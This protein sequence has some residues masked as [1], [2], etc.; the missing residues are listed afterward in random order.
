MINKE[1]MC[2]AGGEGGGGTTT[3]HCIL[4]TGMQHKFYKI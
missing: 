2:Q 4:E 1:H 3:C